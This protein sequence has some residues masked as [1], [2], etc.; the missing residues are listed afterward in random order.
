M[1]DEIIEDEQLGL[2]ELLNG[3]KLEYKENKH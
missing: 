2:A 1:K 3:P